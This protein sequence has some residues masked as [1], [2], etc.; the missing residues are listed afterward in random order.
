MHHELSIAE[1]VK[2]FIEQSFGPEE[3][4]KIEKIVIGIG[5]LVVADKNQIE[6]AFNVIKKE[7]GFPHLEIKFITDELL[8]ECKDCGRRLSSQGYEI[9]CPYC[10]GSLRVLSGD[11]IY[12]KEVVFK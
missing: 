2:I 7:S 12:I 6:E 8:F 9:H 10:G 11:E 5:K 1:R 4:G 3:F